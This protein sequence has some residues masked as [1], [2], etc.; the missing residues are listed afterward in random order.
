MRDTLP[1][2]NLA[3]IADCYMD[4]VERLRVSTL[5]LMTLHTGDSNLP[6]Y[7]DSRITSLVKSHLLI[8][9]VTLRRNF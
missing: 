6:W 5:E 4:E 7:A 8:S 1:G 3:S 2:E 9:P